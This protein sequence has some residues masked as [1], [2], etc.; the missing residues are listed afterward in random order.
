MDYLQKNVV[1][2]DYEW[3]NMISNIFFRNQK[4]Q[5]YGDGPQLRTYIEK[6]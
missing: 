1:I 4:W 6:W 5:G 2:N 3:Y